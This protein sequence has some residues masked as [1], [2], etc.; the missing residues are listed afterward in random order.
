MIG[1]NVE[2][3]V[4][5]KLSYDKN[6]IGE[7]EPSNSEGEKIMGFLDY[8]SGSADLSKFHAK[9]E[10]STHVFICDYADNVLMFNSA[11]TKCGVSGYG[12]FQILLVDDPMG[13]HQHIEVYLKYIGDLHSVM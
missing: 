12:D 5:N 7:V 6:E 11:V 4:Y 2:L 10:E 3:T 8:I 13:L 1:G 9:V